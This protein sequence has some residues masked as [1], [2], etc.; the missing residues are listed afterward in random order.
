METT[1][2]HRSRARSVASCIAL[3]LSAWAAPAMANVAYRADSASGTYA[4]QIY[5]MD[6]SG[7]RSTSNGTQP[8]VFDLA[9]GSRLSL[10]L[11]RTGS[12]TRAFAGV[13]SPTW[14]SNE[15]AS[16]AMGV[17]GYTWNS[18]PGSCP[19]G[20]TSTNGK[21]NVV[22][23]PVD[24]SINTSVT[25]TLSDIALINPRGEPVE[26]FEIIVA[27]GESLDA[28]DGDTSSIVYA[29]TGSGWQQLERVPAGLC[30]PS[31]TC[32][33]GTRRGPA[34]LP[35]LGTTTVTQAH[36]PSP[37]AAWLLT[38]AKPASGPFTVTTTITSSARQGIMLGM[39]WGAV[40]LTKNIVGRGDPSDQFVYRI[41]NNAPTPAS[42][43]RG[44]CTSALPGGIG[45][46][47]T[48]GDALG[49]QDTIS[50]SVMP[51]NV[52]TL[53]EEM[54]P[55][56]VSTLAQYD[57][58]IRCTNAN[59]SSPTVLPGGGATIPY[60]P[61]NPPTLDMRGADDLVDCVITNAVRADVAVLKT[62]P[63]TVDPGAT[64]TYELTVSNDG[65]GNASGTTFSDTVPA[66]ITG[67]AAH[68]G[69]VSGGAA[70]ND[71]DLTVSGNTVGGRIAALPAGATAKIVVTGTAPAS[72][73]MLEN[74]AHV[75][76]P[77]GV[78][79]PDP[80]NNDSSAST[81]VV[82]ADMQ[83]SIDLPPS[84]NAG[85][86]VHGTF[87]CV[88]NGP[89]AAANATC[90]IAG[91]PDG[92]SVV[93]T[94][95]PP[96][97]SLPP[98]GS[99]QCSVDFVAPA[100]GPVTGTATAGSGTPDTNPG[101]NAA[102]DE[103]AIVPVAH[104]TLAK[105]GPAQAIAGHDVS[106][107]LS[108]GNDGPSEAAGVVLDD[109]APQAGITFVSA[110]APCAGGF[111]CAIGTLAANASVE[112]TVVFR[113]AADYA[114]PSPFTN[115]ARAW[116]PTDPAHASPATAV[117]GSAQTQVS[118]PPDLT[119]AKSHDGDFHQ[120]QSGASYVLTVRNVGA[121]P[122]TGTVSVADTLPA[123]LTATA[124]AG[125]GWT[126][127]TAPLGCTRDDVLAAGQAY[128]PITLTVDVAADAAD[129]VNRADVSTPDD[130]G[131]GN[132]RAEDPTTI[133]PAADIAVAKVVDDAAPNVGDVVTFTITATN[134]GPS[135][136]T[137]V[138]VTDALPAGLAFVAA[139]P[140]AG[141]YDETS[142]AWTIPGPIAAGASETLDVQARV[143][144]S[145]QRV[146]TATRTGGDQLDPDPSNNSASAPINGAPAADVQVRKTVDD[147]TPNLGAEVRF[148][149]AVHNDG[150]DDASG[151]VVSDPL[152]A[153]LEFVSATPSQGSYDAAGGAWDVG[154]LAVGGAD[155]TLEIVARVTTTDPVMNLAVRT[156]Q[157]QFDP[158]PKN[159]Q[160]GVAVNGQAADVQ[161]VKTVDDANATLGDAVT[162]TVT[163]TNNGP[164][165]ATNL[166][167]RDALPAGLDFVAATPSQGSYDQATG[168]W[169]VG[170]LAASGA[171]ATA[172]LT[173]RATVAALGPIVNVATRESADQPD[174]N[175]GNDSDSASV[176]GAALPAP[177]A[178]K[179][180]DPATAPV[181]TPVRMTVT[182]S[183]PN[184]LALTGVAVSDAYPA[185]LVNA[186]EPVLV[187][188]SCGGTV[189]AAAGAGSL[190]LAGGTLPA[191]GS[192]AI[193][194]DVV[195]DA[196]GALLNTTGPV[197]SN[198]ALP[199]APASATLTVTPVAN[200]SLV[201]SGPESV[202]AGAAIRYVLTIANAGPS[203]ADGATVTDAMPDGIGNLAVACGTASGG[204]EC[205]DADLSIAG[206]AV[207]GRIARLP[208][209]GSV[210][211]HVDGVA[212]A[213]A[214]TLTNV[215]RVDP[216]A[217]TTDPDDGDNTGSAQ[218]AIAAAAADLAVSKTADAAT[219]SRGGSVT[220]T[221][222]VRNLG[223]AEAT[224]VE[225]VD[226]LPAGLEAVTT[227]GCA[228]DPA[229][230]PACTLG[231]IPAGGEARYT[232]T[233]RVAAD[234]P[235]TLVNS[236]RAS[237]N[238]ADPDPSNDTAI[239]SV[240]VG[241]AA[242]GQADLSVS[243]RALGPAV[244]GGTLS[245]EIVVANAG[246]AVARNVVAHDA[247]PAAL[248]AI[249]T[250][251][252]GN[253]PQGVPDCALGDIAAG[254]QAS[255]RVT[256]RVAAAAGE[257]IV[258]SVTVGAD[259]PDPNPND[260]DASSAVDA[261]A[262][263]GTDPKPVPAADEWA[264]VT[265]MLLCAV[266]ALCNGRRRR[267]G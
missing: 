221:I 39:R 236:V 90:A 151:V 66:A 211:I 82:A 103:L 225:V 107:T 91:L 58:T 115:V 72:G 5:W 173:I 257:R 241:G 220:W 192:C 21:P 213:Q 67:V 223:P 136:A 247:L 169:T 7:Y 147:A 15:S 123:G 185:H 164:S 101:N 175:P 41:A 253:D 188:N 140:S 124:I 13:C 16:S 28:G 197:T 81:E 245:Y 156:A 86:P 62:G 165:A 65:P 79:D 264:L 99:I 96:V 239:S 49:A 22:L 129:L 44:P 214:G 61:A 190:A 174:P 126:C 128:P 1:T 122:T 135:A 161:I 111:P 143:I 76:P 108:L 263:G 244:P 155:A 134:H 195:G 33:S 146:N 242:P 64:I 26:A 267:T 87:A 117:Q 243:K 48:H 132:D 102:S 56:S 231:A 68:C 98:G 139:T 52:V 138:V 145:G 29:T 226:T 181:G 71:A 209:G 254:A 232:L 59:A 183:N 120:G 12:G 4:D 55:G 6:W 199:G 46:C 148:T 157:D 92:A 210:Q 177:T 162:F 23:Y 262:P 35:G 194:V 50:A 25:F 160:D 125:A 229:G 141:A 206:Q 11:G 202:Q 204:A 261:G 167:V 184:A 189:T 85:D 73:Q 219:V 205:S 200:L 235:D 74:T 238:E 113:V 158:N 249:S 207:S 172:T 246:P 256:V 154:A 42:I 150:P 80:E 45:D 176:D 215:A 119:I 105:S 51:G 260:N 198:E 89:S 109:P 201:K 100:S 40:R 180:F 186:A 37:A 118:P 94:P 9:D 152:P 70:C 182:L 187:S 110:T 163:A 258:N 259:T 97:A 179:T 230:V 133:V 114:G 32:A 248:Q 208:V 47:V 168:L 266:A 2:R 78:S 237:G 153:G 137:G 130:A 88:N 8:F 227:Q 217:G 106:Y 17:I 27:D 63:A 31:G 77:P 19:T 170:D 18:Y 212:P 10:T 233:A 69:T 93:C 75:D 240:A 252:C 30:A 222:V 149:I 250:S 34:Q 43:G 144:A 224:G 53:S 14:Y 178:Q 203:A 142:G 36:N 228:E 234:A 38:T 116:S 171:G 20:G 24:G 255:Y 159:D 83:A 251:G 60:D 84:A 196:D 121:G 265:L 191:Q 3:A 104:L 54:A 95:A 127:T 216:P 57:K 218:T 112:V 193:V 131:T 166:V